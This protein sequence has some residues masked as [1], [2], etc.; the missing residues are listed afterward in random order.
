[1]EPA[2]T[3]TPLINKLQEGS[4]FDVMP[5]ARPIFDIGS[6]FNLLL[7]KGC[8]F[9]ENFQINQSLL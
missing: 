3:S 9:T 1:M 5:S 8:I 4:K 6:T 2:N 7:P